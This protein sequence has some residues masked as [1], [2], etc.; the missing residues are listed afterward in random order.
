M[1]IICKLVSGL[2]VLNDVTTGDSSYCENYTGDDF[3]L[4]TCLAVDFVMQLNNTREI[5]DSTTLE[6]RYSIPI[7][8]DCQ[9]ADMT[10]TI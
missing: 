8:T 10:V 5:L 4:K 3:D 7:V 1:C 2:L 6:Q 9:M